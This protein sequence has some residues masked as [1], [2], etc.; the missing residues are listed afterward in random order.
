[1]TLKGSAEVQV[2]KS[3]GIII[4]YRQESSLGLV[5]TYGGKAISKPLDQVHDAFV[6]SLPNEFNINVITPAP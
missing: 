6:L 4:N 1:M 3:V 2:T 5:T